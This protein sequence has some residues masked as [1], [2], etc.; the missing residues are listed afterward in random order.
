MTTVDYNFNSTLRNQVNQREVAQNQARSV[1]CA[2]SM[3]RW[4]DNNMYRTSY[5][6]QSR[7][8]VS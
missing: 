4:D 6:N 7:Y 8:N 2:D 1:S 5:Y 3:R